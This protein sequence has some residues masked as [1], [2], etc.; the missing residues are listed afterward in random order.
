MSSEVTYFR[1]L[2]E[3]RAFLA[4]LLKNPIDAQPSKYLK[5]NGV[6]RKWLIDNLIKR[7]VLERHEKILDSTNS[8]EKKAKYVV[9][10]KVRK[11]DFERRIYKIYIKKFEN[12]VN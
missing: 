1:F 11:K 4:K 7:E 2:S 12:N 6:S 8:D 5:D 3:V 10:F 9:K